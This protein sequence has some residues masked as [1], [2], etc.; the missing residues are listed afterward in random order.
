MQELLT[1][2][3]VIVHNCCTQWNCKEKCCNGN[4][5]F[6]VHIQHQSASNQRPPPHNLDHHQHQTASM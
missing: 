3:R 2:V 6:W 5:A 4:D 1:C